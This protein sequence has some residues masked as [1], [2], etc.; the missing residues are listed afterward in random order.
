MNEGGK[1]VVDNSR[2]DSV[3]VYNWIRNCAINIDDFNLDRTWKIVQVRLLFFFSTLFPNR[4][5]CEKRIFDWSGFR[6]SRSTPNRIV[7]FI[8]LFCCCWML[9]AKILRNVPLLFAKYK[10]P[11]LLVSPGM[12]LWPIFKYE[13]KYDGISVPNEITTCSISANRMWI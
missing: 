3:R 4:L 6:S 5:D 12:V 13:L 9:R 11:I 7:Y 1:K 8:I 2:C 10:N